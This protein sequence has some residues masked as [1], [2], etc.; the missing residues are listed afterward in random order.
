MIERRISEARKLVQRLAHM[1]RIAENH[2]LICAAATACQGFCRFELALFARLL[3][4][5]QVVR[6]EHLLAGC[7]R[8]CYLVVPAGH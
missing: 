4:P 3:A 7:R 2:C 1:A 8:C 6:S 5:A